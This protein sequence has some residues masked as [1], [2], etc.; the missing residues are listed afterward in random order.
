MEEMCRRLKE[1][2]KAEPKNN[3]HNLST[4]EGSSGGSPTHDRLP[5]TQNEFRVLFASEAP[6]GSSDPTQHQQAQ[7]FAPKTPDPL[8]LNSP[9][10]TPEGMEMTEDSKNTGKN[11]RKRTFNGFSKSAGG[12]IT[13]NSF[14]TK[15]QYS[16]DE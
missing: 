6:E 3:P 16:D 15:Y 1:E 11:K 4:S 7:S 9:L 12:A 5:E 10:T 2:E 13:L 8:K 14:S